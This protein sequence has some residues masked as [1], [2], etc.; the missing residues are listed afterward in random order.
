MIDVLSL[1]L[2]IVFAIAAVAKLA[3][4]DGSQRAVA[5][6]GLPERLARPLGL[7]L[8]GVELVIAVML[9]P[10]LTSRYAAMAAAALLAV[11]SAAI[12]ISLARGRRPDCHCFGRLHSAPAGWGTLARN[13]ALA[14]IAIAI[15]LAPAV[16]PTWPLIGVAA[17]VG[18]AGAQ[19]LLWVA[20]L[21][22][23]GRALRRIDA[24]EA[25]DAAPELEIGDPAPGFE[26][27]TPSGGELSFD[28]LSRP[29][30]PLLIVF[31]DTGCGACT[32]M[33]PDLVRWQREHAHRLTLAA[34]GHG[35]PQ[36]L[37]AAAEEHGLDRLLL[38]PDRSLA[39]AYGSLGT[40]S[41]VLV[42]DGRIATPVVYGA[43]EIASLLEPS[44]SELATAEMA[45]A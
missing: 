31:T 42:V 11:F 16:T 10:V 43:A 19:A 14:G 30:K 4:L 3:D 33:L 34:I 5:G 24:L 7:A 28:E 44:E 23:Y 13:V 12:V 41:A 45:H 22:R 32:A 26:L 25:A 39:L 36:R 29:G 1:P 6:F 35:D 18:A 2:A 38:A 21:R 15:V 37:S 20:L 17:L 40:P 9:V 8:P 27:P